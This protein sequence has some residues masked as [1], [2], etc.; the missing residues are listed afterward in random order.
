MPDNYRVITPSVHD[1]WFDIE[2]ADGGQVVIP[3]ESVLTIVV[4]G[5]DGGS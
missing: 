3:A 2:L 5:A 4:Q 1:P